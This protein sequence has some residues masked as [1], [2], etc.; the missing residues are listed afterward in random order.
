MQLIIR[1]DIQWQYLSNVQWYITAASSSCTSFTY[2]LSAISSF[3]LCKLM[4]STIWVEASLTVFN[5]LLM[6]WGLEIIFII[7][8]K[9]LWKALTINSSVHNTSPALIAPFRLTVTV[10]M[11]LRTCWSMPSE[12]DSCHI[13]RNSSKQWIDVTL[14]KHSPEKDPSATVF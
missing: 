1:K 9:S 7:P 4:C 14:L 5:S 12:L 11:K 6:G 13:F 10:L 2:S 8:L 3:G